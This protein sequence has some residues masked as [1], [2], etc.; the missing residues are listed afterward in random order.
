[1]ADE[2]QKP[3]KVKLELVGH[4]G[5]AYSILGR[6]RA[7]ARSGGWTAIQLKEYMDKATSG[8]YNNLLSVTMDYFDVD[9]DEENSA[10]ADDDE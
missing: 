7:A 10:E 6:A 3:P 5:N 2:S 4:D 9:S 8:D 1:M